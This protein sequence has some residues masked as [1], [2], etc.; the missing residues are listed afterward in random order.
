[1]KNF[2]NLM[3]QAQDMQAKMEDMQDRLARVDVTG[4]SGGG[5]VSVKSPIRHVLREFVNVM[6]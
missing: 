6:S 5:M 2:G 3:K 1:M 4:V